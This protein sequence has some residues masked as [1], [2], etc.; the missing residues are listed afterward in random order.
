MAPYYNLIDYVTRN[1]NGKE[2]ADVP[3]IVSVI[4]PTYNTSRFL[5]ECLISVLGQ[6]RRPD[7]I[8]IIDDGSTDATPR[9]V[10]PF[11][12][13]VRYFRKANGGASSARNL[14]LRYSRGNLIAFQD[15]D[16][17]WIPEKLESQIKFLN[18]H[19][20]YGM[21]YTDLSEVDDDLRVLQASKFAAE[22]IKPREGW[23]FKFRM[24]ADFIFPPTTLIRRQVFDRV[25][26]FKESIK[27]QED[28]DFFNRVTYYFPVG[29]I[30]KAT[31]LRRRHASNVS[32][33]YNE[34][35]LR[36]RIR[37]LESIPDEFPVGR[38]LLMEIRIQRAKH[39]AR[40]SRHD[41]GMERWGQ[42][43]SEALRSIRLWPFT[44][45]PLYY[46]MSWCPRGAVSG[47]KRLK[48][49][50]SGAASR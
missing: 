10:E 16:D 8:I 24:S 36:Y 13:H 32:N 3:D 28:M 40:L 37:V 25:G 15:A 50:F 33:N 11:R 42:S 22:K 35:S 17:V 29:V 44:S 23:I 5:G 6:T 30:P 14:G 26:D 49:R 31:V 41:L 21:V 39:Y 7:E 38:M 46:L 2:E 18:K 1:I 27:F 9:I 12:A 34:G 45:A 20:E 43:R 19:R 47:V 48:N 4:I